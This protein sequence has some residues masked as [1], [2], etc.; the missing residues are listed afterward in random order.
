MI[1]FICLYVI[2]ALILFLTLYPVKDLFPKEVMNVL[3][4][5]AFMPIINLCLV[6]GVILSPLFVKNDLSQEAAEQNLNELI[7]QLQDKINQ[8]N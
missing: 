6:I 7:K 3:L 2:P 1:W 5:F 4:I 8:R